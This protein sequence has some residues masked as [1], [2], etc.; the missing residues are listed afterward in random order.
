MSSRIRLFPVLVMLFVIVACGIIFA[1]QMDGDI[2]VIEKDIDQVELALRDK[3][4]ALSEATI[5]VNSKDTRAY[6]INKARALGYLMPGE[7]YF[8]VMN[9]EV[10]DDAP[11]EAAV[12]AV[13]E[14]EDEAEVPAP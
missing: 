12:E 1:R 6:I 8:V 11:E 14:A 10:L 9:P 4:K 2:K 5:E 3:Q 7:I 13:T